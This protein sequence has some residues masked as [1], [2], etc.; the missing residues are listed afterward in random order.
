MAAIRVV[1]P[2]PA[3]C[4]CALLSLPCVWAPGLALGLGRHEVEEHSGSHVSAM[5]PPPH[6][7][8]SSWGWQWQRG[9]TC[10]ANP[11][12]RAAVALGT[13]RRLLDSDLMVGC[14]FS[15]SVSAFGRACLIALLLTP[16]IAH[17]PLVFTR[18]R[19]MITSICLTCSPVPTTK[20]CQ[21]VLWLLGFGSWCHSAQG[22]SA[23][24]PA[25]S[26]ALAAQHWLTL[27]SPA[28][29]APWG[30]QRG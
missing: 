2:V 4:G 8:G 5:H 17:S 13:G 20:P 1:S 18:I 7:L 14:S 15:S 27:L 25:M 29:W 24:P 22:A 26:L 19:G 30:R 3:A 23:A 11:S 21:Q 28:F 16:Y 6:C 9:N 12:A 10:P